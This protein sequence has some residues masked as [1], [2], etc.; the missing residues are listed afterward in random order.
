MK[1]ISLQ[2][3]ITFHLLFVVVVVFLLVTQKINIAL[4]VLHP[5]FNKNNSVGTASLGIIQD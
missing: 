2:K 3:S 4:N 5:C 1:Y